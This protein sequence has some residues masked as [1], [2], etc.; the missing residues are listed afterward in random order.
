[1]PLVEIGIDVR[2]TQRPVATLSGGERQS[3]A[4]ARAVYFGS[5]VLILDEPTSALGVTEA[6]V[7]LRYIMRARARGLGVI[8]ITHNVH[9]AYPVADRFTVLARG[10][11]RGTFTKS[12]GDARGGA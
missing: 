12:D 6:G 11:S 10:R 5:K 7:V 2:N 3:V 1:M 8:F 9:R 4:I